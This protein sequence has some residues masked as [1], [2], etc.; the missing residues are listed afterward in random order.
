[1]TAVRSA[2]SVVVVGAG[3][4]GLAAAIRLAAR[5]LSVTIVDRQSAPGGKMRQIAVD[6]QAIDSGPTVLTMRWVFDELFEAAGTSLDPYVTLE[7]AEILARHAWSAGERLDLFAD[8]ARS[9][10]AIADFSN[11]DEADRYLAFCDKAARVYRTVEDPFI[12]S[13]RP[14]P[15]GLFAAH[16]LGGVG[17][18]M[19][20]EPFS[21][22][23]QSLTKQFNDPRLRQLFARYAT[24]CGASP[25]SAPATLML[26]AHV[27][28]AGVWM[29]RGG[30]HKL[31]ESLA[32]VALN[33]GVTIRYATA[34]DQVTVAGGRATG[35]R[36]ADGETI[37][38][39]AVVWNGDINAL[40]T[41]LAGHGV[42]RAAPGTPRSNRSLSAMTVSMLAE[43]RDFPLLRHTVFFCRD[44]GA[45]FSDIF[46]HDRLPGEPTVYIC[47]Q[48]RGARNSSA[49]IDPTGPERLFA[50]INAPAA[51]DA[52][53]FDPSETEPCL[54]SAFNLLDRCGLKLPRSPENRVVTTP[55]DFETLFPATGGALYGPANHGWRASFT[56]A[57]ART[58][59]PG[60]YLAGGSVHPG[61]GVPM[62]ALSGK[63]AAA[64]VLK[65][66]TLP[67]RSRR[68]VISGGTST[69]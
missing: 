58:R 44:Y 61:A 24:Y 10:A 17:D 5:G 35:V 54:T 12:K 15:L 19:A 33:L 23:W 62:A 26:V 25:F 49:A 20:I 66:L 63:Q 2:D 40:A 64:S 60:L 67:N 6:G 41:G 52:R 21:T 45:E 14:N 8:I 18:L 36:L 32:Y 47:A 57:G 29:V 48:D 1:M 43:V 53:P 7:P 46:S 38:T 56:R 34:V 50:I 3:I 68:A 69:R 31:A 59:I 55:A 22:L 4:A 9:A 51:G 30:M 16:G 11:R 28:Q 39:D 65:D 27:E 42:T 13:A 37:T